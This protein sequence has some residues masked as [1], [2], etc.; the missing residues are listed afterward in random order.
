[1]ACPR[2]KE[3]GYDPGAEEETPGSAKATE[4]S[5][6]ARFGKRLMS[7]AKLCSGQPTTTWHYEDST[8]AR[9]V[10]L[11]KCRPQVEKAVCKGSRAW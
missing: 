11:R 8:M 10:T 2:E 7:L 5:S 9:A 6:R 4:H 1:M 3:S